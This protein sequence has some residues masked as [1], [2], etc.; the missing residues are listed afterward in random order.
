MLA[1]RRRNI[2]IIHKWMWIQKK[3]T[4]ME[5]KVEDTC[6][7]SRGFYVKHFHHNNF[8]FYSAKNKIKINRQ[9][10]QVTIGKWK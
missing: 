6:M 8:L 1:K 10:P 4:E 7:I 3:A 2:N 9:L 5:E